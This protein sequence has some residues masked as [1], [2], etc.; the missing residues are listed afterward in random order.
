[1]P[2]KPVGKKRVDYRSAWAEARGIVWEYR[3]RLALGL[4]L[5]MASRLAG[6]V[7][8]AS[9]KWLIDKVIG[10]HRA[11]LL[12]K[13]ALAVGAATLVQAVT[14]FALSQV[15][16]VAAQRAITEMRKTVQEHVARLP[17]NYFDS[18]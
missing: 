10:Q 7:L 6:L 4:S 15:L 12:P 3:W 5:V 14:G 17:V 1:M 2:D 13:I 8:P 18:T 11:D 16:G 9:S